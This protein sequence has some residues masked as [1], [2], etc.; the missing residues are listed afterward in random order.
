MVTEAAEALLS[1]EDYLK[2]A[3]DTDTR[4]ELIDGELVA[5]PPPTMR[6]L[7]IAKFIERLFDS[8]I[9]RLQLPW[10]CLR[11]A[12]IRTGA[13]KSRLMDVCVATVEQTYQSMDRPAVFE[14]PPLLAVEIVSEESIKRDYRYKRSE[15]AAVEIPEYWI[16]DPLQ[17][18]VSVLVLVEGFYEDKEFKGE[19]RIVSD[20]FE[21][22]A[23]T[24]N[25]VLGAGKQ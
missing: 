9:K 11:E 7:L 21:E 6:H 14:A 4:Y 16:V 12:G 24:A 15:Y 13:R 19:A 17:N 20:V 8:E 10:V 25:Q 3:N 1:F 18:K 23:V 5:V 22:L 2:H